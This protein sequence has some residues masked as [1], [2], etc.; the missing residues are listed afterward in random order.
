[1]GILLW[2]SFSIGVGVIAQSRG[3]SFW[4]WF[5]LSI[6]I[7]PLLGVIIVLVA[8]DLN[9]SIDKPEEKLSYN[10]SLVVELLVSSHNLYCRNLF[11]EEEYVSSKKRVFEQVYSG[12]L[13]ENVEVFLIKLFPLIEK[14]ILSED[15]F[16]EIK[17]TLLQ[18]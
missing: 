1:M 10:S 6:V 11:S 9:R 8:E 14:K 15:E 17:T 7:S 18:R 16:Y 4:G 5:F 12:K 13:S 2:L 3:R